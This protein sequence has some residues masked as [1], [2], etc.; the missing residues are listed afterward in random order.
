MHL[1][2]ERLA[3]LLCVLL[4]L[5]GMLWI[6]VVSLMA[7]AMLRPPRMSA[8]KAIYHLRRLS[9]GDLGLG[10]EEENFRVR[11]ARSGSP[12]HI[13]SWW[14]PAPQP[15][16]I[17]AVLIHGYAD[18]KVGAIAWA[19]L[20][21]RLNL[22]ILA[23]DLRAHGDSG[24]RFSTGGFFERDD[25]RQVINE[26][27]NSRPNETRRMILLGISLGA[28]V[29]VAV[30]AQRSDISGLILESPYA[31]YERVIAAHTRLLGLPGGLMLR[32]AIAGAK[33]LSGARFEK[34]G[35]TALLKEVKCPVLTI[36]GE[37]D[38]LLNPPDADAL[39]RATEQIPGSIY[40]LV[41]NTEHLQALAARP[42]EYEER[43][44][45]FVER[46]SAA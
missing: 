21:H 35:T 42:V 15:S 44:R 18:A 45:G 13:S 34:V 4:V 46:I 39:R 1:T 29:A 22:N 5:G 43:V 16:E 25:V 36:V 20:L 38:Q 26:I 41:E 27:I 9:P 33:L 32:T 28:A 11:D 8:G 3:I 17:C 31:D 14:I 10:F 23:I 2:L 7:W 12:L 6:A 19:P 30:A 40:W 24:G 37:A